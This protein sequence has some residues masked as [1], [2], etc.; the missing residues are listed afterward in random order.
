MPSGGTVGEADAATARMT[1]CV[2][3]PTRVRSTRAAASATPTREPGTARSGGR[4][5]IDGSLSESAT[6]YRPPVLIQTD[7]L[8]QR[9][10]VRSTRP[11]GTCRGV[12]NRAPRLGQR[13]RVADLPPSSD[14][15]S[16]TERLSR[17]SS[18]H[19]A[20]SLASAAADAA[21]GCSASDSHVSSLRRMS[22]I[23]ISGSGVTSAPR[24]RSNSPHRLGTPSRRRRLDRGRC[25]PSPHR[26]ACTSRHRP[27]LL[28]RRR[29]GPG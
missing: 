26:R 20:T 16:A 25:G 8:P 15:S 21:G 19:A 2:R 13:P 7:P 18:S 10:D 9:R 29:R 23:W 14:R 5:G 27:R 17:T 11:T 1:Q 22:P 3:S 24:N 6:T 28:V 12:A 4:S